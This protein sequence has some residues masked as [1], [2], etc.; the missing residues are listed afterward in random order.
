MSE[1]TAVYRMFDTLGA[2]L[3]VGVAKSFGTRWTSHA[4]VQSWW[5]DVQR[6]TVDWHPSREDALLE[7]KRAIHAEMPIHNIAGSPW[8]KRVKDDGTGFYV[9]PKALPTPKTPR[10]ARR[11]DPDS[12]ATP[13]QRF[14]APAEV[15]EAFGRICSERGVQRAWRLLELIGSDIRKYGTDADR[16]TF[17]AATREMRDRRSRKGPRSPR[18][19][20]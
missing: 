7:E 8:E 5:G 3:Y 1:R 18:R 19:D 4:R 2:L 12:N 15:W 10:P 17:G 13:V 11:S 9:V 14:R 16:A 20:S 6:Q